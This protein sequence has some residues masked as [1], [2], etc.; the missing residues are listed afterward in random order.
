MILNKLKNSEFCVSS[1]QK[2]TLNEISYLM[3]VPDDIYF[4]KLKQSVFLIF[5]LFQFR[6]LFSGMTA[7]FLLSYFNTF[8]KICKSKE[9]L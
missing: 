2:R 5:P 1:E 7:Y 8:S 6:H 3:M 9:S 4:L